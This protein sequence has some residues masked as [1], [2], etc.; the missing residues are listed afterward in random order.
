MYLQQSLFH[1]NIFTVVKRSVSSGST[2][3]SF[4]VTPLPLSS[5]K[6]AEMPSATTVTTAKST[7][8]KK[9]KVVSFADFPSSNI[10]DGKDDSDVIITSSDPN[11]VPHPAPTPSDSTGGEA[12]AETK[13]KL[14]MDI[15]QVAITPAPL[16]PSTKS[17]VA[18]LKDGGDISSAQEEGK[19]ASMSD[20]RSYLPSPLRE[21]LSDEES[22]ASSVSSI[23]SDS[24]SLLERPTRRRRGGRR[25]GGGR[26]KKLV[27]AQD[28]RTREEANLAGGEPL[29]TS[30][31]GG[32]GRRRGSRGARSAP[33]LTRSFSVEMVEDSLKAEGWNGCICE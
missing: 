31:R 2:S 17:I 11:A 22:I 5:E 14:Q 4:V 29:K 16:A 9:R 24:S 21:T 20:D 33:E 32:R 13:P 27:L 28:Q 1:V 30:R 15:P 10:D 8:P 25:R 26:G 3:S 23:T 19:T 12:K 7:T 6:A 18:L